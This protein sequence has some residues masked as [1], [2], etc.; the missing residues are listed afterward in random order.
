MTKKEAQSK[1]VYVFD[2]NGEIEQTNLYDFIME[3]KDE[4]TSP[5]GVMGRLHIRHEDGH[6]SHVHNDEGNYEVWTWGIL[7]NNPRFIEEFETE[8]GA[9][10]HIFD[11]VYSYDFMEDDQR[12]ISYFDTYE[13]ALNLKQSR[14][15]A[16]F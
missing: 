6:I 5:V 10:E 9:E 12:D 11:K 13:E 8:E 2:Y 1:T 4:T 7:G 16:V 14:E 3:S 15:Q